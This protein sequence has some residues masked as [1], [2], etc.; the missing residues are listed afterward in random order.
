[1]AITIAAKQTDLAF[2]DGTGTASSVVNWNSRNQV[3]F[4]TGDYVEAGGAV[5]N[6]QLDVP[7]YAGTFTAFDGSRW[8]VD[9]AASLA[10]YN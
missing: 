3:L 2:A 10:A 9:D 1:N 7:A 6:L 5:G 4:T 8:R